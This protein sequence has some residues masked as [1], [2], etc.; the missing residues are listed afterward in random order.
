MEVRLPAAQFKIQ[1]DVHR[2]ELW[3][4]S[5]RW[6]RGFLLARPRPRADARNAGERTTTGR[7]R[8]LTWGVSWGRII[9]CGAYV[10][11]DRTRAPKQAEN[12][13]GDTI[14]RPMAKCRLSSWRAP[15]TPPH[16][17]FQIQLRDPTFYRELLSLGWFAAGFRGQFRLANNPQFHKVRAGLYM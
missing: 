13:T 17:L 16:R 4:P 14:L 9:T 7:S 3:A 2:P 6:S 1:S 10:D 11:L 15:V 5:A 12:A 8:R